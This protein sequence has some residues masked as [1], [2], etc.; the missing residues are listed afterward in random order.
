M[1]K[2]TKRNIV[3]IRSDIPKVHLILIFILLC[4]SNLFSEISSKI[5]CELEIHDNSSILVEIRE[6]LRNHILEE[7][8]LDIIRHRKSYS[9]KASIGLNFPVKA[10]QYYGLLVNFKTHKTET[11]QLVLLPKKGLLEVKKEIAETIVNTLLIEY[12]AAEGEPLN[13]NIS[14]NIRP[15]YKMKEKLDIQFLN[16]NSNNSHFYSKLIS[17]KQKTVLKRNNEL[18]NKSNIRFNN[19]SKSFL[20]RFILLAKKKNLNQSS[21][22]MISS[23]GLTSLLPQHSLQSYKT[24]E[25]K[26]FKC[27]LNL[28]HKTEDYKYNF[29]SYTFESKGDLVLSNLLLAK[30]VSLFTLGLSV[31]AGKRDSVYSFNSTTTPIKLIYSGFGYAMGDLNVYGSINLPLAQLP[32]EP[33]ISIKLPT[34]DKSQ[35]MSVGSTDLSLGYQSTL[36][37]VDYQLAYTIVGKTDYL[38]LNQDKDIKN[39][40]S[41][42]VGKSV[43]H[44]NYP[45]YLLSFAL[46]ASQSPLYQLNDIA[47]SDQYQVSLG[48]KLSKSFSEATLQFET[49][50]GLTESTPD[51][52]FAIGITF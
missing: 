2:N 20:E 18:S 8:Q 38:N 12:G 23:S 52:S 25:G 15:I 49:S 35:I 36:F 1:I 3:I 48:T 42:S 51:T 22:A 34:G 44:M 40:F 4:S 9:K 41:L 14:F 13:K 31:S 6:T 27:S 46:Y 29:G 17:N 10:G 24:N 11:R 47:G 19:P 37:T 28:S 26:E 45:D 30:K 5:G 16:K 39:Y 21:Y 50:L 32:F 7:K 43:S 33:F